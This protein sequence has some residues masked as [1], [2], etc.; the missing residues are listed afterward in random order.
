LKIL[1]TWLSKPLVIVTA[2]ALSSYVVFWMV[3]AASERWPVL[4]IFSWL[5]TLIG[6]VFL[7]EANRA[8]RLARHPYAVVAYC[9]LLF[10]FAFPIPGGMLIVVVLFTLGL[11]HGK[12]P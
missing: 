10:P 9:A 11:Y 12:M 4:L 6:C 2:L 3:R 8:R 1:R 7:Y 5:P